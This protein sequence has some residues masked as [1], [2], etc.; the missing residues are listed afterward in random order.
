MPE[1]AQRIAAVPPYL[2][3]E[4]D[5]KK[6]A[7]KARGVD[8][9]SLGIGDPDLPTPAFVVERMLAEVQDPR[10]HQYPDYDGTL[11]FRAAACAYYQKRFGV[12]LDPA[13]EALALIGSKEGLS[14]IIWAYVGP[15][16]VVLTPDPAY[17]VY[18]T[19]TGLAGGEAYTLPLLAENGFLPDLDAVPAAVAR[20][21]KLLFVNYPN[22]PTGAVADLEFY[23]RAV[24]FCRRHDILLVSDNA[25]SEMT[26]DGYVA[27]SVLQVPGAKDVAVEF[28]S[29]SKPF[30]MTGWRI[31][32]A[33]GN[34]AALAALGIIKT[35]TDSG[36]YTA[37]QMAAI[38]AL[39]N[40]A[41]EAFIREM[42][43]IYRRRRDMAVAGLRAIG[44][45][46][47]PCRGSFYLWVPVPEGQTSAGF[48]TRL[49][50]EAG[51]VVTPGVGYGSYGEGYIRI[52]LC[53]PEERLAEAM[54][55]IKALG[56]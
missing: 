19:H 50:E 23:A 40:P 26:Y 43:E 16:D 37:V 20:R 51:V 49:L 47:E 52:A 34:A 27:P 3:A 38:E 31:A 8:V 30:N 6:A 35:N 11:E 14:H 46:A 2:F 39:Q 17:P 4:I 53:L 45:R 32:F 7:V 42:N 28:W 18:R 10:W 21:A 29:L 24:D 36:Q 5:K 41:G 22:N 15:G 25:Y 44:L 55:R 13:S 1:K 12:D 48:A 33:V 56:S 54:R 9:I